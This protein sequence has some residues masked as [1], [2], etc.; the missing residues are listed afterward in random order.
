MATLNGIIVQ[1][2][3]ASHVLYGL[4][5]QREPPAILAQVNPVTRTPLVATALT[6]AVALVL[7]LMLPLH[8]LAETTSRLTLVVFTV[9][10][11]SLIRIKRGSPSNVQGS[12]VAPVWVPWAAAGACL[13]LLVLDA[14]MA[15]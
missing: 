2:I 7:A 14:I 8:D 3:M 1:I 6:T 9:V 4:A 12:F 10:N 15:R 11:I 13:L 5:H